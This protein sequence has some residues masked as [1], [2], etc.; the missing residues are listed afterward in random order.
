MTSAPVLLKNRIIRLEECK[1]SMRRLAAIV[2]SGLLVG[3]GGV[4]VV[5]ADLKDKVDWNV[6][7]LHVKGSPLS[8]K[9]RLIVAGGD[10][11]D[12][13]AIETGWDENRNP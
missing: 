3:C 7:F 12:R 1:D 2:V 4:P 5:P 11:A 10:G 9:G 8:Y 6:S 13:Q